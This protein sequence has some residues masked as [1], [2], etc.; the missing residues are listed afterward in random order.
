MQH[1]DYGVSLFRRAALERLPPDSASDLADL[2]HDLVDRREMI[3]Y[4]VYQ[5]F[6]EIGCPQGLQ[7]TTHYLQARQP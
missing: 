6:Y 4:E 2:M 1:I 7:E 3:G 5:R